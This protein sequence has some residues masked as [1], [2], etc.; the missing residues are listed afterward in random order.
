MSVEDERAMLRLARA[1]TARELARIER[2]LAA[3]YRTVTD[4]LVPWLLA[5]L[6]EDE[7]TALRSTEEGWA[8][9]WVPTEVG[10]PA[11]RPT[12]QQFVV[13]AEDDDTYDEDC[14]GVIAELP[15]PESTGGRAAAVFVAHHIARFDPS[16]VLVEVRAKRRVVDEHRE[17]GPENE[18]NRVCSRCTHYAL[19]GAKL[20]TRHAPWP[21]VTLRALALPYANLLGYQE[22]WR[23]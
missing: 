6:A 3:T 22:A 23:P 4:G 15:V 20:V 21:C 14:L 11:S 9:K 8:A 10:I 12:V 18:H 2:E 13:A 7:L 16:R 17:L 5:Q 19:D 1:E